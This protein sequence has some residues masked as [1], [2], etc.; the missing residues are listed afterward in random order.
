M[1][2]PFDPLPD[3]N[4]AYFTKDVAAVAATS[5]FSVMA[6]SLVAGQVYRVTRAHILV[7]TTYAADAANF[8]ALTLV[9]NGTTIASWSTQT[10]AQGALTAFTL[11]EM[12][13]AADTG[14]NLTVQPG[15]TLTLVCTKNGSAANFTARVVVHGRFVK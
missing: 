8:Y 3:V 15:E 14:V 13:L 12:V 2:L 4:P 6:A 11:A 9:H 5:T 7:D 1:S 10:S